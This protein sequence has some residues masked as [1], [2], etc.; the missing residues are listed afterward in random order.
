[1]K[2]ASEGLTN[3]MS[4]LLG[5]PKHAWESLRVEVA[6][7]ALANRVRVIFTGLD[8]TFHIQVNK[9]LARGVPI[10]GPPTV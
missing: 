4:S 2:S 8:S 10:K 5:A 9:L 7:G 3:F 1:M 6:S